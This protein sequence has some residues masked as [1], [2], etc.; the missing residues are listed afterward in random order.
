MRSKY[1]SNMSDEERDGVIGE[2]YECY[3]FQS[4]AEDFVILEAQ[5]KIMKEA[6]EFYADRESNKMYAFDWDEIGSKVTEDNGL[7]ARKALEKVKELDE[8]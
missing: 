5:N 3:D 7:T 1:L 2:I 8:K 4:L 6:L